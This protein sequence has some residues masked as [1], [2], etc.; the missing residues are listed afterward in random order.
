MPLT[1]AAILNAKAGPK[2][3]KLSDAGGLFVQITPSGGKLW[4]LKYRYMGKEKLLSFGPHPLVSLADA[5]EQMARAKKLLLAGIDPS[6]QRKK[7]RAAAQ[8]KAL[9]TFGPTGNELITREKQNGKAPLNVT[10]AD[11][12]IETAER[13]FGWYGIDSV[14]LRQI[15]AAAGYGNH[16]TVQ[17]HFGTKEKL[18]RAI[19]GWRIP[20]LERRREALLAQAT[21]GERLHDPRTLMRILLLPHSSVTDVDGHHSYASFAIQL[22]HWHSEIPETW[23]S[24]DEL[25][26]LTKYIYELILSHLNLPRDIATRRIRAAMVMFLHVVVDCDRRRVGQERPSEEYWEDAIT[27]ATA[28]LLA[29]APDLARPD[30]SNWAKI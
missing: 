2:A 29:N 9:D 28:V 20:D 3:Y 18:V 10:A 23:L 8:R 25:A 12:L 7:D 13:L 27:T 17:Y 26:P 19:F 6:M 4:R 30:L 22:Y 1:D 24:T 5:R 11:E 15:A 14:S 21:A 16:Y